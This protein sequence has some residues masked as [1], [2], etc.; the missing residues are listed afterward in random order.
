MTKKQ[1]VKKVILSKVKNSCFW[2][3][4]A[5][6]VVM[7]AR[8]LGLDIGNASAA[9]IVDALTAVLI[10]VGISVKPDRCKYGKC[11]CCADDE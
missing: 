5:G 3:A 11:E 1:K 8:M 4:I 10:I 6:A 9:G 2:A 7:L